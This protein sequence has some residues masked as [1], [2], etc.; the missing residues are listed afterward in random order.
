MA[1]R[2]EAADGGTT[3][4]L[5]QP[6]VCQYVR[7]ELR[8]LSESERLAFLDAMHVIYTESSEVGK[9]KYGAAFTGIEGLEM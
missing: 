1:L 7:R 3:T 4:V 9:A 5:R 6:V 8:R 2:M